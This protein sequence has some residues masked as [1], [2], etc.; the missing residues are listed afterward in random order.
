L[1]EADFERREVEITK[2]SMGMVAIRK[3]VKPGESVVV[4]GAFVLAS[5]LAKSS[6]EA[7]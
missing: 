7:D 2:A 4:R 5:E 6:F 3:G 1:P